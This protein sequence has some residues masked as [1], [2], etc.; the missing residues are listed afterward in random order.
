[1]MSVAWMLL[2]T[3]IIF[4]EK[5]L[6]HGMWTSTLVGLGF[7]ALGLLMELVSSSCPAFELSPR[8]VRPGGRRG[9]EQRQWEE[10]FLSATP[11]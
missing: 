6:P 8:T 2:L 11:L 5:V 7:I 4:A 10:A 9:A 3:V 1:M